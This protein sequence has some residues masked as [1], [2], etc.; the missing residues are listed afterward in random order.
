MDGQALVIGSSYSP[1]DIPAGNYSF[2]L[3]DSN[4]C[5]VYA[6]AALN[7]SI[8]DVSLNSQPCICGD[9]KASL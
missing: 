1:T 6:N 7:N 8:F 3:T 5:A 9:D 2:Y 4:G